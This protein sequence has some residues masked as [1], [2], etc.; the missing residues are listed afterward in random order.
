MKKDNIN[1]NT[2]SGSSTANSPYQPAFSFEDT[3][4]PFIHPDLP[5]PPRPRK[6]LAQHGRSQ[7][8]TSIPTFEPDFDP[9]LVSV[10]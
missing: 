7:S 8:A 4:P 10:V 2:E 9:E 1:S 3:V 5:E 6:H